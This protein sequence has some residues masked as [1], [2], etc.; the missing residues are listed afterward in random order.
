MPNLFTLVLTTVVLTLNI[1]VIIYL[2][3]LEKK[4]CKCA[5][6]FRRVYILG[7]TI[8]MVVLGGINLFFGPAYRRFLLSLGAVFGGLYGLAV[9]GA[10]ITNVVFVFQYIADLKAKKCEC[11]ESVYRDI[12]Y[13]LAI[14]NSVAYGFMLFAIVAVL[15]LLGTTGF[16]GVMKAGLKGAKSQLSR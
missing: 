14:F 2:N 16:S 9:L 3:D 5:M 8:A 10:G 7:F 15:G 13:G 11:S 6:D 12:M 4:G 1:L